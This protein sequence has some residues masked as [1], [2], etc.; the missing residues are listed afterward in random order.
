MLVPVDGSENSN[1]AEQVALDMGRAMS[2][3][4]TLLHVAVMPQYTAFFGEA[5]IPIP[6]E[7]IEAIENLGRDMLAKHAAA[8]VSNGVKCTTQLIFGH[9]AETIC[10]T[11]KHDNYNLIIIGSR[12]LGEIKG[13]LLG[14]VS[15]RVS[16]YAPCSVLI[17]H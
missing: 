11:A 7:T 12:G 1:K 17:V 2:A 14:S 6:Q 4:V 10:Q 9:P 15:D 13:Y 8:F 16:H 3:E 5:P